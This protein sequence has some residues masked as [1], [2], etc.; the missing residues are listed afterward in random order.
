M[1]F[2]YPKK[3]ELKTGEKRVK[4][5]HFNVGMWKWGYEPDIAVCDL[6]GKMVFVIVGV[7]DEDGGVRQSA[8]ATAVLGWFLSK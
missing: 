2:A 6:A 4:L 1:Q 5:V 7:E 3:G 8:P